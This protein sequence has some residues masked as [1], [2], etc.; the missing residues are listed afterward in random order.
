MTAKLRRAPAPARPLSTPQLSRR[1]L[2]EE[3]TRYLRDALLSGHFRPG[4]RVP[5]DQLA[6]SL[7]I[8]TMP[9]REALLTLATDGLLDALP[10]RGFRV[11]RS[12]PRDI[13]DVF[14]VHAFVGGLLAGEAAR[15][16]TDEQL[17]RLDAIQAD[18]ERAFKRSIPTKERA[19]LVEE[20][21]FAFHRTINHV[22]D[23]NRLRW[24]LRASTR[25]V[26]RHFYEDIPGWYEATRR[27]HLPIIDALR[28]RSSDAAQ[29]LVETHVL[30]AGRLV[31]KNLAAKS[32]LT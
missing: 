31:T 4:E 12:T 32:L 29:R 19:T 17:A 24:F 22:P 16:I 8:S 5:M 21:N 23:A 3:T 28:N 6:E 7:G 30:E 18:I 14:K 26:P 27:D 20:L 15:L 1:K 9:V 2:G 11:A 25:Y 13:E 10:N